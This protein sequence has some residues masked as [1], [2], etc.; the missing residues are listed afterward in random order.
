MRGLPAAKLCRPG[1]GLMTA[2]LRPLTAFALLVGS[3]QLSPRPYAMIRPRAC[4]ALAI[5][6]YGATPHRSSITFRASVTSAARRPASSYASR[7]RSVK[8]VG[9]RTMGSRPEPRR[10]AMRHAWP[11][12]HAGDADRGLPINTPTAG[13]CPRDAGCGQCR[14]ATVVGLSLCHDGVMFLPA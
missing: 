4:P 9:Q 14:H 2:T 13:H 3:P 1:Q 11:R 10:P 5:G 12:S 7:R 8:S 6:S